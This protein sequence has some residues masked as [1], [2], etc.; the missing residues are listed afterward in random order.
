MVKR[1]ATNPMATKKDLKE[2][3]FMI[4]NALFII[5]VQ[6]IAMV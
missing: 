4:F 3:N 5:G 2:G 1:H 6:Q